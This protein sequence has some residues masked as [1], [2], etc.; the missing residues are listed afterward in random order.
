MKR[1]I[2]VLL[3][4][5]GCKG[6]A[7]WDY[8][9]LNFNAAKDGF[10]K[11]GDVDKF[12]YK[13]RAIHFGIG[14]FCGFCANAFHKDEF[15]LKKNLL[16]ILGGASLNY[17]W[18]NLTDLKKSEYCFEFHDRIFRTEGYYALG[19]GYAN[20]VVCG[21]LAYKSKKPLVKTIT[22]MGKGM[23]YVAQKTFAMVKNLYHHTD[24][25]EALAI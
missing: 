17:G 2:F 6:G 20:G 1:F 23:K 4:S 19:F 9:P 24:R 21:R 8:V 25:V 12:R 10:N 15:A 16:G 5:V 14:F 13:C 7:S 11:L 22:L 18:R 3:V